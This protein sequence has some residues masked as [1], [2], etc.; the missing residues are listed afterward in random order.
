MADALTWLQHRDVPDPHRQEAVAD[1][2]PNATLL[3]TIHDGVPIVGGVTV[4]AVEALLRSMAMMQLLRLL[5][6]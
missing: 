5:H 3:D 1:P 6:W 2:E 4:D